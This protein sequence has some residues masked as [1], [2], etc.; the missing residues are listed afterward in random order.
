MKGSIIKYTK[1]ILAIYFL[2]SILI[3]KSLI[4]IYSIMGFIQIVAR[5]IIAVILFFGFINDT[6]KISL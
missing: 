1:L 3:V 2:C 6:V 5:I 4:P